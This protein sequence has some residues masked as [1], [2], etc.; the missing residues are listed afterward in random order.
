MPLKMI[1][2]PFAQLLPV[3]DAPLD[4]AC[5]LRSIILPLAEGYVKAPT[6]SDQK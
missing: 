5:R 4:G 6:P 2:L 3:Q 1:I